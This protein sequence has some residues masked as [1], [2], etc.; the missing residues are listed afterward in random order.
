MGSVDR[1]DPV[2]PL[3]SLPKFFPLNQDELTV[4]KPEFITLLT[5][6]KFGPGGRQ[7]RDGMRHD[8]KRKRVKPRTYTIPV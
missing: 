4:V 1:R 7:G 8:R 3:G 6:A 2:A 5:E